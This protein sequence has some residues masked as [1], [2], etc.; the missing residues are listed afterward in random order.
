MIDMKRVS[1]RAKT[2]LLLQFSLLRKFGRQNFSFGDRR[3]NALGKLKIGML[4]STDLFGDQLTRYAKCGDISIAYQVTD[5]V[6]GW[7]SNLD[8]DWDCL[9][10][11]HILERFDPFA[12][13]VRINK[14]CTCQPERIRHKKRTGQ[15]IDAPE[16]KAISDNSEKQLALGYLMMESAELWRKHSC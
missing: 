3:C 12:R 15:P 14:T 8:L 13:L 5:D 2:G 4:L 10:T 1:F 9:G 7:F 11:V 16:Q 6:P